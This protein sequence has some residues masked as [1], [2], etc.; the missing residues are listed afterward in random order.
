[1]TNLKI[2]IHS[3]TVTGEKLSDPLRTSPHLRRK[4]EGFLRGGT[5]IML[6]MYWCIL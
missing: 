5:C 3:I 4:I 1:M 6:K 2:F